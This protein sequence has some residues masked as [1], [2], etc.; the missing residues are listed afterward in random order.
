[1]FRFESDEVFC[2]FFSDGNVCNHTV[3]LTTGDLAG[4]LRFANTQTEQTCWTEII[5]QTG[6]SIRYRFPKLTPCVCKTP[7]DC[8]NYVFLRPKDGAVAYDTL[9]YYGNNTSEGQFSEVETNTLHVQVFMS[10]NATSSIDLDLYSVHYGIC[11]G[12]ELCCPAC[13]SK[14]LTCNNAVISC[15]SGRTGV[16]SPTASVE[17]FQGLKINVVTLIITVISLIAVLAILVCLCIRRDKRRRPNFNTTSSVEVQCQEQTTLPNRAWTETDGENSAP[18][19]EYSSLENVRNQSTSKADD[20]ELPPSY[21]DA[22]RHLD[23]Y[24]IYDFIEHI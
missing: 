6:F 4:T 22:I 13:I 12:D 19:P 5:A 23:K 21:S 7:G 15:D 10:R 16:C 3:T 18:P 11:V 9:C 14:Q 20:D 24:K 2:V 1:M 8:Q 17:G